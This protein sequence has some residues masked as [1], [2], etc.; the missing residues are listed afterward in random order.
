MEASKEIAALCREVLEAENDWRSRSDEARKAAY[1][2]F[3]E[4]LRTIAERTRRPYEEILNEAIE[5]WITLH[6]CS[7][8]TTPQ[9]GAEPLPWPNAGSR[10]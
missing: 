8:A 6:F 4:L 1:Q 10:R 7:V 2:R 3:Q 5:E 9:A